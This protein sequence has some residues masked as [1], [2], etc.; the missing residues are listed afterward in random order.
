M[1]YIL[2]VLIMTFSM[3][4]SAADNWLCISDKS[5]GF[6]SKNGSWESV[7]FTAGDKYMIK[8]ASPANKLVDGAVY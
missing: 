8:E 3:Q 6:M 1:K 4:P 7:N 5:T 2:A